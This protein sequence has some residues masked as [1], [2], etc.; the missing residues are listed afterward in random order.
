MNER[1]PDSNLDMPQKLTP[2]V[3]KPAPCQRK[4][5]KL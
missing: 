1:S 3:G 5:G 2:P 4:V